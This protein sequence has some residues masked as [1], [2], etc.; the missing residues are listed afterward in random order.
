MCGPVARGRRVVGDAGLGALD[1][2]P[3]GGA[4]LPHTTR[5]HHCAS[6]PWSESVTGSSGGLTVTFTATASG[7]TVDFDISYN[8]GTG[9]RRGGARCAVVR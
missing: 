5:R 9:L 7:S 3:P 1:G 8:R 6:P 2:H 4:P